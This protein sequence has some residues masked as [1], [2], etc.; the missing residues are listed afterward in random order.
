MPG[1]P[2]RRKAVVRSSG[3]STSRA[4]E[5][6]VNPQDSHIQKAPVNIKV[7]WRHRGQVTIFIPSSDSFFQRWL[8]R[9]AEASPCLQMRDSGPDEAGRTSDQQ[10]LGAHNVADGP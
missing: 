8:R 3:Q 6:I 5:V 2:L 10:P 9:C 1:Q 4:V 7:V